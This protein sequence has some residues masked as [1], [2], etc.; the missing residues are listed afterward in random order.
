MKTLRRQCLLAAALVCALAFTTAI[1]RATDPLSS[2]ARTK[3]GTIPEF[4]PELGLG[5][6]QGYLDP[7]S[8]PNS[9]ALI[10]PPPAPGSAAFA[11]DVEI[12]QNSFAL[13][14]TPRFALAASDFDLKL[15]QFV[16]DFSC[17]L[18]AQITKENAPYLYTLLCSRVH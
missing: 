12:A 14:D 3:L 5:A 9:L 6:L 10:P 16:D 11:L 1:V 18:N 8:L 17:A 13:R 15:P 2:Q 4:H 7:K